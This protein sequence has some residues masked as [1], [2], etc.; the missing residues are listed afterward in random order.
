VSSKS[1]LIWLHY[2]QRKT[3]SDD[4]EYYVGRDVKGSGRVLIK[5]I[6]LPGRAEESHTNPQ[7]GQPVFKAYS[8]GAFPEFTARSLSQLA[9]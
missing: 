4:G 1:I 6:I 3:K 9:W 5:G 7:Q 8:N 2:R